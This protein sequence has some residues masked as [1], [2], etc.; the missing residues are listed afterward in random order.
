MSGISL[1]RKTCFHEWRGW[2]FSTDLC[3]LSIKLG[4]AA[5]RMKILQFCMFP[6]S[7][8]KGCFSGND[9]STELNQ[10]IYTSSINKC[11]L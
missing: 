4:A 5:G 2:D 10:F 6:T 11:T 7:T 1:V 8:D 9:H 3:V